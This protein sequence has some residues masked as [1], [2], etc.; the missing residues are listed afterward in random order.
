VSTTATNYLSKI[1]NLKDFPTPGVDNDSQGFR[2]QWANIHGAIDAVNDEISYINTYAFKGDG[3]FD[4]YGNTLK[5]V[6]LQNASNVMYEYDL[7]A[8]DIVVDYTLGGYQAM[9]VAAGTHNLTIINWPSANS[10]NSGHLTLAV[11]TTDLLDTSITFTDDKFQ[12]FDTT[13]TYTLLPGTNLFELWSEEGVANRSAKY[14]VKKLG[15]S[16]STSTIYWTEVKS[17]DGAI[18][19]RYTVGNLFDTVVSH[20]EQNESSNYSGAV[21]LV[22][23]IVTTTIRTSTAPGD[24]V[25]AV[26]SSAG[27][28]KGASI[29]LSNT[30]TIYTVIE[31]GTQTNTVKSSNVISP[32]PQTNDVIRFVNPR[33]PQQLLAMYLSTSTV[34]PTTATSVA[35]E[36]RGQVYVDSSSTYFV[37]ADSTSTV[38]LVNKIQISGD[39][40]GNPRALGAGSTATTVALSNTSTAVAS[41]EWVWNYVNSSTT[42]VSYA[43]TSSYSTFASS[44]TTA[45]SATS[46]TTLAVLHLT[47][48]TPRTTYGSRTVSYEVPSGG[49]DGDVWYQII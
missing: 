20:G 24:Q 42:V 11:A 17:K 3:T 39:Q 27:I 45:K 36:M 49:V 7:Q 32:L 34:M 23:N 19:N 37:Y 12:S 2:D 47:T 30:T 31:V 1:Y 15:Y 13:A 33:F 26:K 9:T 25:L 38:G 48:A 43:S 46:A 6:G 28:Y 16:A 41:T 22:P 8:G 5:N 14:Y 18:S 44:S 21:A 4:F 29:C 35:G 10:G 40:S